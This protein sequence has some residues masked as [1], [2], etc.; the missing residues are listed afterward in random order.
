[1]RGGA[2]PGAGRKPKVIDL[3][4]VEKLYSLHCSDGDLAGWFGVSVRTIENRKKQRQFAEAMARGKAKGCVALR[5]HQIRIVENGS[6]HMAIWLGKQLLGQ[7]DAPVELS[8]PSEQPI[9]LSLEVIDAL[10]AKTK[11]SKT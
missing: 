3:D 7:K 9:K 8:G 10:L 6:A 2:R 5:R 1:M 4:E 11:R